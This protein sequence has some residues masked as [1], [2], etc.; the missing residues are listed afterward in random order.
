MLISELEDMPVL[1]DITDSNQEGRRE[2]NI[3]LKP[4]AYALG[5]RLSDIASQV[6]YGFFGQEVQRIQRGRDEVKI[7]VRYRPEDRAALGFLDQMRI[8]TPGGDEYPFS[9]LA[10]YDIERGLI[11]INHL[12]KKREI[13]VEANLANE[14]DDL[15]PILAEISD[16]IVPAILARVN[17][18]QA[19]FEGQSRSREKES[20]SMQRAFPIAFLGMFILVVLVF[21]ST[22]QAGLIFSLIPLGI[23]G[24]IWGHGIQGVQ[25]SFLSLYGI[26]ALS[27]IIIN[28]SI[29]FVDQINRN[30]QE[31]QKI[32]DA[33][34]N[35]GLSRLR[36]ILLTTLTTTFGLAPIILEGSRQAQFLIPM[37]V[38]VA[39]GLLF[40][41]LILLLVLPAGFLAVNKI[42]FWILNIFRENISYESIE[43]AMQEM[44]IEIK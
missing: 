39:Y 7:W 5:L 11:V 44:K 35:A 16:K 19:S 33:V 20:R 40:G 27:G 26:L 28:D 6:R 30:L 42:R 3:R 36:P 17:G 23:I 31:G 9:E 21:R 12:D 37:A 8:R 18:V 1:K 34:Y 41:T 25:L 29:V 32:V 15:P 13:K 10:E 14:K 4:R 2:L 22:I 24:A 43:P 38:S